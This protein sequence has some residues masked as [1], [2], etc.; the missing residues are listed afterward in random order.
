VYPGIATHLHLKKVAFDLLANRSIS[1]V[2][3]IR[4]YERELGSPPAT[5]ADLVPRFLPDV[6][7]NRD[8][9]VPAL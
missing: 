7:G 1:L 9:E 3:A 2:E 5:L 6:P 4:K 8:V